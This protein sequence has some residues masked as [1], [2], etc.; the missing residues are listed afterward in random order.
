MKIGIFGGSFNPPHKGHYNCI[1]SVIESGQLEHLGIDKIHIIPC[2][3][4]PNKAKFH[5][6][7]VA[8]YKMCESMFSDLITSGKVVIDDIENDYIVKDTDH[9]SADPSSV[10]CS[11]RSASLLEKA[12]PQKFCL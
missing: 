12:H 3:Q 5:T 1:K 7:F 10:F 8:R 11:L 2:R 4:N 9:A 6:S